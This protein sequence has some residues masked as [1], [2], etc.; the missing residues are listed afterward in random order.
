MRIFIFLIAILLLKTNAFAGHIGCATIY[1]RSLCETE[2][3]F[4]YKSEAVSWEMPKDEFKNKLV[5]FLDYVL[6]NHGARVANVFLWVNDFNSQSS[7]RVQIWAQDKSFIVDIPTDIHSVNLNGPEVPDLSIRGAGNLP[8]PVDFGFTLGEVIVSCAG[9][10]GE[11]HKAWLKALGF[12]D[13]QLLLPQIFLV[14]VPKF[15]EVKTLEIFKTKSDF[16]SLFVSTELSPV[17]EGNG[18]R[19]MAFSVHF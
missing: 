1:E 8:Y 12:S 13:V 15:N 18:F 10:C 4:Q 7:L 11:V 3:S 16:N 17:L 5:S 9:E 2:N 6:P 14:T 19:E